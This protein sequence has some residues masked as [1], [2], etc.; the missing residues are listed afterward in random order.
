M[1]FKCWPW[2]MSMKEITCSQCL[3]WSTLHRKCSSTLSNGNSIQLLRQSS[4]IS[5]IS[6][7]GNSKVLGMF[8]PDGVP[9]VSAKHDVHV[10]SAAH[11]STYKIS[12]PHICKYG[13][14][15][16][17]SRKLSHGH[18]SFHGHTF[19]EQTLSLDS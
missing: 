3:L 14:W 12:W 4:W 18:T 11:T 2:V 19:P 16:G 9:A 8:F 5:K 10:P 17:L 6:S 15:L 7:Q 13:D 1:L